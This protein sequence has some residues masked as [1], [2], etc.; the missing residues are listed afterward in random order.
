MSFIKKGAT[1][2]AIAGAM[3][4]VAGCSSSEPKQE[5]PN[6][7]SV[8]QQSNQG[9]RNTTVGYT[10]TYPEN[11][12][13]SIVERDTFEWNGK[14]MDAQNMSVF[15][16]KNF[17]LNSEPAPLLALAT[18]P[19]QEWEQ[20]QRQA[21]DRSGSTPPHV[22]DT[23]DDKVLVAYINTQNPYDAGSTQ[24]QQFAR[25]VLSP[26]QVKNAINW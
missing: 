22:I 10:F 20:M 12:Q 11:W 7:D 3:F 16:Y 15:Y 8:I 5:D 14:R 18:Y 19:Q 1:T 17:E 24:G 4:A 25:H 9:Y 13:S 6:I 23:R 26:E 21:K 2:L